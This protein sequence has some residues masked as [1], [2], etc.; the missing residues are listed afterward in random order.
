M[1]THQV[2]RSHARREVEEIDADGM[3]VWL[4]RL[5]ADDYL[6]ADTLTRY[7]DRAIAVLKA[8]RVPVD[9]LLAQAPGGSMVRDYVLNVLPII[10]V[11]NPTEE[12][13]RAQYLKP[14]DPMQLEPA[15]RILEMALHLEAY[16]KSADL[17]LAYR[18]GRLALLFDIYAE[19]SEKQ[20]LIAKKDRG[21]R[22]NVITTVGDVI[23]T[24]V[25]NNPGEQPLQLWGRFIGEL[26]KAGFS[27]IEDAPQGQPEK[28]KVTY[29]PK[30]KPMV[31]G[32]FKNRVSKLK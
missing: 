9:D 12:K 20:R 5:N 27:P 24:V 32:T 25:R 3:T 23:A 2:G 30:A 21:E 8:H 29:G 7:K 14:T 16:G 19:M 4:E 15:A 1:T 6:T 13:L 31:F 18:F 28:W 17:G 11:K 10:R 26:E 22:V